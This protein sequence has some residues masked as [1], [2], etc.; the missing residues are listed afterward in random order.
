MSHS[1]QK[2]WDDIEREVTGVCVQMSDLLNHGEEVYR[3]L[4]EVWLYAGNSL[5]GFAGLL[6]QTET[7]TPEQLGMANDARNALVGIHEL[8]EVANGGTVPAADRAQLLRR[9]I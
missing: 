6:F 2:R 8:W 7:P 5:E 4:L 1:S 9:M 3:R